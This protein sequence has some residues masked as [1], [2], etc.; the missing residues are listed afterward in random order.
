MAM[1]IWVGVVSWMAGFM[2]FVLARRYMPRDWA[3]VLVLLFV[4]TPTVLYTG[5]NGQIE[6]KLALFVM[7]SA[8]AVMNAIQ[9]R[10]P[11]FVILAG[12]GAGFFI[13]SKYTGVIFAVAAAI[14]LLAF[15]RSPRILILYGATALIAGGQWYAWNWLYTADPVF[16]L[17]GQ[18]LG[19]PHPELWSATQDAI[20]RRM[21]AAVE[22]PLPRMPW[23]FVFYPF[24]AT[25]DPV[26]VL[27]AGR[28][29]FG[30]FGLLILPFF[31]AGA[32]RW[33]KQ[34]VAHPLFVIALV[35]SGFYVLW[36]GSGVSQRLR[37]L[38]PVWPLFLL[39]VMA[40]SIRWTAGSSL[41]RPLIAAAIATIGV[42]LAGQMLFG[43]SYVKHL[44]QGETRAA[45]L[46][47]SVT[48][49]GFIS[50]AESKMKPEDRILINER[51]LVYLFDRPVFYYH[52][53]DQNQ[54][55]ARNA[56]S[57][58]ARFLRELNA[59][60]ITMLLVSVS[61][62]TLAAAGDLGSGVEALVAQ[63]C[64]ENLGAVTARS[65]GSRTLDAVSAGLASAAIYRLTPLHCRL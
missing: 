47:R 31:L 11:A 62:E 65:F 60:K 44:M 13:G 9:T 52:D 48:N 42:Q 50:P 7:A 2:L 25:I 46:E 51:Q 35:L 36:F 20:F 16:P 18:M 57:E 1:T 33:R 10:E 61:T 27:E 14:P 38:L 49:F 37:H 26:D 32:Y 53:F 22:L 6:P 5:G 19:F 29:G 24:H 30:P 39:C 21:Q 34:I 63:G 15:W 41:R 45:F 28:T 43:I 40:V 17:L 55:V 59:Q 58:P 56:A 4:S 12:L 54:I 8:F 23:W 3:L 64:A